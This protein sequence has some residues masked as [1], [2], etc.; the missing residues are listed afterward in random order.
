MA[1]RQWVAVLA[2]L[3]P[4]AGCPAS[5]AGDRTSSSWEPAD[6]APRLPAATAAAARYYVATGGSDLNPGSAAA[7]FQTIQKAADVASA[8][9]TVLVRPGIYTGGERIVSLSR[10]GAAGR[11]I[12]FLSERRWGAV[13]DGRK[14]TSLEG[15]YFDRGVSHVRVEGF[16]IR[17]LQEHG[18]DFYGGGVDQIL[19]LRNH[20]HH[21]G[22]NCTDTNNGRTGASLGAG[23]RRVTFDGNVWH[24]IGRYAP[25][26]Q[27]CSPRTGNYQNHDHGIYVAD[28]GEI[29]IKN[30]V[31]Y[32]FGRGW[33]VHRYSSRDALTRGLTIVNNTFVGQN[34]YRPGHIILA[35][36]TESLRI[37]N[38]IFY[39]PNEAALYFEN[40]RFPRA[41]VRYNMIYG[42]VT[43]V[44]RPSGVTFFRNWERTNPRFKSVA[45]FRLQYDSPAVDAGLPLAEVLEDA[46]AVRRP[47]GTGYDLGAYER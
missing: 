28:A 27:G 6:T 39:G 12:T 8:G 20:V 2:S 16:E 5:Q 40:R 29:T 43:K 33:P 41:W 3:M 34:P 26:E 23:A 24:D 31:F 30:N 47:R 15:W 11:P 4:L 14:G 9:D 10:S 42:G 7:P 36:P 35:S 19:I 22:R 25:G 45:D 1:T 38:N 17:G 44:G 21:V 46:D 18:F 37:E 32:R 13:L